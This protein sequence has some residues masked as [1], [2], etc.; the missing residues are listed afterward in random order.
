MFSVFALF[1]LT[2]VALLHTCSIGLLAILQS[3]PRCFALLH[4]IFGTPILALGRTG[5]RLHNL[6][7]TS[8]KKYQHSCQYW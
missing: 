6:D 1:S 4:I 2:N 3:S 8:T 7:T 5:Y